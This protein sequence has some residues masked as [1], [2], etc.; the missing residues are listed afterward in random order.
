MPRLYHTKYGGA[1]ETWR[2]LSIYRFTAFPQQ[3]NKTLTQTSVNHFYR[4]KKKVLVLGKGREELYWCS[5]LKSNSAALPPRCE[6]AMC[7]VMCKCLAVPVLRLE[8][9]DIK[10]SAN[11]LFWSFRVWKHG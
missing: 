6:V 11:L 7:H 9:K 5:G 3:L 1:R 10:Q 2:T 4:R 8:A